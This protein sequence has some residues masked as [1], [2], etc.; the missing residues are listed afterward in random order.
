MVNALVK[1]ADATPA[2]GE[3]ENGI[4]VI[5]MQWSW[6]TDEQLRG[7][8]LQNP[9]H[10]GGSRDRASNCKNNSLVLRRPHLENHL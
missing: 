7:C 1:L 8:R 10:F 4:K 5:Q 2:S 6:L 3:L 9:N